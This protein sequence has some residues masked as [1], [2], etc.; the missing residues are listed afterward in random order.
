MLAC[1][2]VT[3]FKMINKHIF[4]SLFICFF[5]GG[6]LAQDKLFF[7]N[8]THSICKIVSINL[9]SV[10]YQDSTKGETLI[11]ISKTELLMAEYHKSGDVF[12]FGSEEPPK[13]N[14]YISVSGKDYK[15]KIRE[16]ERAL[17]SNIIGV[18]LPDIGFGR[19]TL[20]YERL[21]LDKQLGLLVP[22]S[23]TYD[24]QVLFI[25]NVKGSGINPNRNVGFITGLDIN[26]Y[27]ETRSPRTKFFVGPRFRYGTD[28]IMFNSTAYTIQ[29]QNGF[30]FSS[31]S[32][33]TTGTLAL[34]FGFV[35]IVSSPYGAGID[36]AQSIP[37]FSFTYRL[38]FRL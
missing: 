23:L 26:Y 20:T 4:F 22:F 8:G 24:P 10:T 7:K 13:T 11:T 34:G 35:R 17:P 14:N 32:G 36:P 12:V 15:E 9:H 31:S 33:K 38:G 19:V 27:F 30:F 21:I 2:S 6:M 18:Q 3:V 25:L 29:F 28:I 5:A 1:V 37:W 16:K